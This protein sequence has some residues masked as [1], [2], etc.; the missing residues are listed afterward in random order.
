MSADNMLL[1]STYYAD[2]V[3]CVDS[4]IKHNIGLRDART[5]FKF[6][7]ATHNPLL[8]GITSYRL[9]TSYDTIA[10]LHSAR[11]YANTPFNLKKTR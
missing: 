6:Q 8:V 9:S 4:E 5:R 3:N 11:T 10:L 1:I 2:Y 7:V